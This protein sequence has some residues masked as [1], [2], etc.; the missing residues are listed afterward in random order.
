MNQVDWSNYSEVYDLMAEVNP[1]YQELLGYFARFLTESGLE[2]G[3]RFADFGA[4]TGNFSIAAARGVTG[5]EVLHIETDEGMNARARAKAVVQDH[6]HVIDD[7]ME[8]MLI[9]EGT[10]DGAASVHALYTLSRPRDFLVRL[11]R[12]LRPGARVFLCDLGRVL[13]LRD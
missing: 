6:F 5:L 1:A 9:P 2:A 7:D 3:H 8:G 12:G 13:D 10:L 4:G 11:A